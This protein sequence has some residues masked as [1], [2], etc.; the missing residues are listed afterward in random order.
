MIKFLALTWYLLARIT[1]T[2]FL[3]FAIL[4]VVFKKS[5]FRDLT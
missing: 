3:S 2:L 5:I 4:F 1:L